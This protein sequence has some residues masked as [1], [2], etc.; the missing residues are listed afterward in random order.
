M[1]CLPHP[2]YAYLSAIKQLI[3][4]Q[5]PKN[6]MRTFI[7]KC[8]IRGF[9]KYKILRGKNNLTSFLNTSYNSKQC[10]LCEHL[11]LDINNW[12]E[13]EEEVWYLRGDGRRTNSCGS[14]PLYV[15]RYI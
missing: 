14:A 8:I 4:L 6:Y 13:K 5:S 1:V 7:K 15:L 12:N 11:F 2:E 9:S 3:Q 10:A